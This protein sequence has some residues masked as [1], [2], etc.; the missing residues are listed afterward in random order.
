MFYIL[1]LALTAL[2]DAAERA[3]GCVLEVP[4]YGPHGDRLPFKVSS[5]ALDHGHK[6]VDLL[7]KTV[8]G[9]TVRSNGDRVFFSSTRIVGARPIEV[10]LEGPRGERV[11]SRIIVT[12]CRLRRSLFFGQSDL[13]FDVSAVRITGRLS[14]C[15]F[16]GDWWV[17]AMLMFGGHD[18]A[19]LEDGYVEPD[20][21]F[22]LSV[23]AVGVRRLVVIG[24]GSE[25]IKVIGAD[26]VVGK[27]TDVGTV[28][29]SG[30]CPKQ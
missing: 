22:R 2:S 12:E 29:L 3:Q 8:E 25:P 14:G 17:R 1:L 6:R 9:L 19:A 24:R 21:S 20:G 16:I 30:N 15:R 5:V 7:G 11:V 13:G 26:I 28:D 27:E 18:G 23:A 4:V 10:T